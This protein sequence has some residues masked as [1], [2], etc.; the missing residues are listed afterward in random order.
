MVKN[1]ILI[2]YWFTGRSVDVLSDFN[3]QQNS[4]IFFAVE[5][6]TRCDQSIEKN[7][8]HCCI[9]L[10]LLQLTFLL[11]TLGTQKVALLD[12]PTAGM[13][14]QSRRLMWDLI[15]RAYIGTPQCCILTTHHIE[16]ADAL[17][18]RIA[19]MVNGRFQ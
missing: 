4:E 17:C 3:V 2:D 7:C 15:S 19:I 1:C 11:S 18:S 5:S 9:M 13:D 16:E 8:Q 12:E 14:P 6:I 10:L